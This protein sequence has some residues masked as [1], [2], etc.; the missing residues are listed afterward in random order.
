MVKSLQSAGAGRIIRQKEPNYGTD[1]IHHPLPIEV[2]VDD[3]G[4]RLV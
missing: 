2:F 3:P 4:N 1:V